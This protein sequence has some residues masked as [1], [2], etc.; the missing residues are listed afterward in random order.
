MITLAR[1]GF[2]PCL[3]LAA[4]WPFRTAAQTPVL[5]ARYEPAGDAGLVVAQSQWLAQTV[6]FTTTGTLSAVELSLIRGATLPAGDLLLE[7]RSLNPD[8]TPSIRT[9]T[10]KVIPAAQIGGFG[11]FLR[12]DLAGANV[13][14][15]SGGQLALSLRT[16]V[17]TT[18]PGSN[19]FAW[20]G[21]APGAYAD[22]DGFIQQGFGWTPISYDFGFRAYVTPA[23]PEPATAALIVVGVVVLASCRGRGRTPVGGNHGDELRHL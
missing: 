19:P 8:G 15:Q 12:V 14:V 23:V 2:L 5:D 7:V 13:P 21:V 11:G 16:E 20:F 10:A 1:F 22:G 17:A 6:K 18:G 4:W 3:L 9:Q